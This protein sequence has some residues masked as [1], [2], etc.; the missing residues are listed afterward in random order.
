MKSDRCAVCDTRIVFDEMSR[1]CSYCKAPEEQRWLEIVFDGPPEAVSGRFVE[2]EG[3]GGKSVRLGNWV[4]RMD[5]YWAL[6]FTVD[7]MTDAID[8]VLR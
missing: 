1:I 5:G 6:R 3:I 2:V 4:K 7:D 8:R